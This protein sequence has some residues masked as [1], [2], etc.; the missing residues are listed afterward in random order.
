MPRMAISP[1]TWPC[2]SRRARS[3]SRATWRRPSS[4]RC[5][6]RRWSPGSR[7]PAPASST[8]SSR[9]P[10]ITGTAARAR[11]SA[12]TTAAAR[13]A[14]GS[15]CMSSSS[16]PTPPARCTS[17]MAATPPI[18]ATL[19]NLLD[20]GRLQGAPR[21]LRQRR[22]PA[23][24]H[25]RHQRLAALPGVLRR[26]VPVPEQRLPGRLPAPDRQ[27]ARREHRDASRCGPRPRCSATCRRTRPPATRTS[28]S[29]P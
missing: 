21:V 29:T 10:P 11:R 3:A 19:A 9:R 20:A 13:W 27:Q 4:T 2:S 17:A 5:R 22:R 16:R 7:S 12:A 8:S 14:A 25:P 1:P 26:A 28:T 24:G 23:D 6:R 15:A 18:G